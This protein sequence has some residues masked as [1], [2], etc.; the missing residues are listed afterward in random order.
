MTDTAATGIVRPVDPIEPG[1]DT[2]CHSVATNALVGVCFDTP[3]AGCLPVGDITLTGSLTLTDRDAY[4]VVCLGLDPNVGDVVFTCAS[5]SGNRFSVTLSPAD[6][7]T[8]QLE[9]YAFFDRTAQ[10]PSSLY[11]GIEVR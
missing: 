10:Y 7:G 4:D 2:Q 9:A 1:P 6:T 8:D 11:R 3:I 5:V